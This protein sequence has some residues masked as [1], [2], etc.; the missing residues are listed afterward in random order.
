MKKVV[1]QRDFDTCSSR[2]KPKKRRKKTLLTMWRMLACRK[3]AVR[4]VQG[5][6]GVGTSHWT[7]KSTKMFCSC[8]GSKKVPTIAPMIMYTPTRINEKMTVGDCRMALAPR[9]R[10]DSEADSMVRH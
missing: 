1:T 3:I 4:I 2:M 9:V 8:I 5:K 6:M 10:S 7:T